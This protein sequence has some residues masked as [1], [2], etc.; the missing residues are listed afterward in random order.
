MCGCNFPG[1]L[2]SDS[3]SV[4]SGMF[5][6]ALNYTKV[7]QNVKVNK[8]HPA[9]WAR[10]RGCVRRFVSTATYMMRWLTSVCLSCGRIV[11]LCQVNLGVGAR[12][13]FSLNQ[14]NRC[15]M[16]DTT[17]CLADALGVDKGGPPGLTTLSEPPADPLATPPSAPSTDTPE[18]AA[19]FGVFDGG[20]L[21]MIVD[22]GTPQ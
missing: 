21:S 8:T 1:A 7:C 3:Y 9:C 10:G 11:R 13:G 4:T 14:G 17:S 2:S 16:E 19:Y 18:A 20:N 15:L 12:Y 6:R 22:R 5:F